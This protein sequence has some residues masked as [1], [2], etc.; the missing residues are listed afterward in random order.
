MASLVASFEFSIPPYFLNNARA[1]ATLEGIALK[2]DPEFNILRVIYPYSIN[3]LMRNPSVSKITQETFVHICE[4]P[5]T[6]LVDFNN[7]MVLLNDWAMFTGYRK[8]KVFWDLGKDEP[9]NHMLVGR[10]ASLVFLIMS[11][12]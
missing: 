7:F 1:L 5:E 11:R 9:E 4:N 2:L 12:L 6:K 10:Q 3:H 8:R